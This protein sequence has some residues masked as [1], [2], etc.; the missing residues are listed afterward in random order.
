MLYA[1]LIFVFTDV[2]L[3]FKIDYLVLVFLYNVSVIIYPFK[4]YCHRCDI[5]FGIG[6]GFLRVGV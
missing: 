5:F 3:L 2:Y 1:A 4:I 6:D